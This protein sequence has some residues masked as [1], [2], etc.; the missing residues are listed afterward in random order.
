MKFNLLEYHLSSPAE[1]IIESQHTN[2]KLAIFHR[3]LC[4]NFLFFQNESWLSIAIQSHDIWTTAHTN[5]LIFTQIYR[6][7]FTWTCASSSRVSGAAGTGVTPVAIVT[8][9][10]RMTFIGTVQ[11]FINICK[12]EPKVGWTFVQLTSLSENTT[13]T[14]FA[15]LWKGW[16]V[17][18]PSRVLF[19][20]QT[21]HPPITAMLIHQSFVLKESYKT[22][23][24]VWAR[25][26]HMKLNNESK[27]C[28]N[29]AGQR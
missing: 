12:I 16:D 21:N 26:E 1:N 19:W 15:I 5:L 18:I 25:S 6:H 8:L 14:G 29:L 13:V 7:K 23:M 20:K 2:W 28:V 3:N 24:K 22:S 9:R 11:A 4:A 27:S 17:G 10:L